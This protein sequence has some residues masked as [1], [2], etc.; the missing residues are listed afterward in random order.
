MNILLGVLWFVI[1][2]II[3]VIWAAAAQVSTEMK[4]IEAR[5]IKL[6]GKIY[7]LTELRRWGN[8]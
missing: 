8:E 5:M 1:G 7:G 3:G 6:N 4:A 2:V